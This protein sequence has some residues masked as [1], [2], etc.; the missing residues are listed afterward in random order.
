VLIGTLAAVAALLAGPTAQTPHALAERMSAADA[1]VRADL[2]G[3]AARDEA[4]DLQR[5]MRTL[6]RHPTLA[7]ATI[8][9]L[10]PRLARE[11]RDI[12]V[13]LRE[14]HRLSAG[15]PPHRIR[16]GAAEPLERLDA[17]YRLAQR[18][19][20]V[21]RHVL[22]AVNFV[23]SQFGRLR[24]D[25]VSGAQG[26]MQFMPATWRVYGMGGDIHEP[27]DAILGAAN[28][29][30]RNGAPSSYARA[31]YRYNPSPLYVD[32]V[33]RYARVIARDRGALG[34][35]YLWEVGRS[36]RVH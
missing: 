31:L 36:G 9:L 16:V 1:A 21:G 3:A 15:W 11:T 33:R 27:R 5:A 7:A 29:L 17:H 10:P 2:P 19:F 13:A 35:L 14:L 20:G 25:S 6:S 8:R 26:P 34:F 32:A 30:R 18:R 23:E 28:M 4:V 12:T 22:A 24:N